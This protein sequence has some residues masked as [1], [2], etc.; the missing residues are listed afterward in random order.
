MIK[1]LCHHTHVLRYKQFV[2][3]S[4]VSKITCRRFWIDKKLSEFNGDFIKNYDQNSDKGYFA[5]V[6]DEYPK[7]K[8]DVHKDLPFWPER[9]K[10]KKCSKLV[11]NIQDK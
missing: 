5:E 9:K 1:T 8:F 11:S 6:D 4:N 2:C 7:R 3:M 10:I